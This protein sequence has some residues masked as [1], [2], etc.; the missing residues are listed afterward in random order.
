MKIALIFLVL[1]V[2]SCVN[3]RVNTRASLNSEVGK[4]E[5]QI[6]LDVGR[7]PEKTE[8]DGAGGKVM[9]YKREF[10][11]GMG[12]NYL[13]IT[14]YFINPMGI[15]YTWRRTNKNIPPTQIIIR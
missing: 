11:D 15:C 14:S 8:S 6:M 7:P 2:Y 12:H 3:M 4:T 1:I 10:T 13:R 5:N 9:I